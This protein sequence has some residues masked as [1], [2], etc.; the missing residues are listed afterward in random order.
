LLKSSPFDSPRR[1]VSSSE[2]GESRGLARQR[3]SLRAGLLLV[4]GVALAAGMSPA[5]IARVRD[6]GYRQQFDSALAVT[7]AAIAASPRDP[8]GYCWHAATLQ[9]LINDSGRGELA[10]SFYRLSDRT[11]AVCKQRLA[12]LNRASFLGWQRQTLSAFSV[13]LDVA[14]HLKA[15]LAR[16]SG[17]DDA[18][19]GLAMVDYFR[20]LSNRY[21]MGLKL[22]GSRRKAYSEIR[23]MADGGGPLSVPAQMMMAYMLKEDGDC[24][25]AAVYCRRVLALYPA[26]RSALRLMRDAFHRAGRYADAVRVGVQI[27]SVLAAVF[28]DNKYARAENWIV[29]GKA[30]AQLGQKQAARERFD[31][32]IA[33]EPYQDDVPWLPHYVREAKQWR[34]KLGV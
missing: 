32:I 2:T 19:L 1:P 16:D 31:R 25:S 6:L 7:A 11:I 3:G 33:W 22:M 5:D 30:Y 18:R 23:P 14:P 9:L 17:L 34:K 27:D 4:A 24:E 12:Q 8:A 26:N 20:A 29:C 10:D 13:F 21:T 28:A 15:A